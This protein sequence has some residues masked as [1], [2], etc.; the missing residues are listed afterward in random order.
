MGELTFSDLEVTVLGASYVEVAGRWQL[1]REQDAPGGRYTLLFE[2][3]PADA[4]DPAS[5][6]VWRILHD[7]TSSDPSS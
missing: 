6:S 3:G 4:G 1:Q 7:H 5:G 2:R